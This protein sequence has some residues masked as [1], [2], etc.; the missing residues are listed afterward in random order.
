MTAVIYNAFN[1][2]WL[3]SDSVS[4][5]QEDNSTNMLPK[6]G[7][8]QNEDKAE[9]QNE[10]KKEKKLKSKDT[11]KGTDS[12]K[13]KMNA[14]ESQTLPERKGGPRQKLL[15]KPGGLWYDLVSRGQRVVANNVHCNVC[16]FNFCKMT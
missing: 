12:K 2:I 13:S 15:I 9:K 10:R 8:I 1:E 5:T 11:E 16:F 4:V 14:Q 6:T 3:F 7:D